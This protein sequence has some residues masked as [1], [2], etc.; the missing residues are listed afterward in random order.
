MNP[1]TILPLEVIRW[2]VT[3]YLD[4]CSF[5]T[6][7]SALYRTPMPI[8]LRVAE[9][10]EIF[11]YSRAFVNYYQESGLLTNLDIL[12]YATYYGSPELFLW[13]LD[14]L[15]SLELTDI[16]KDPFIYCARCHECTRERIV[17]LLRICDER[18]LDQ[19]WLY[20]CAVQH[21]FNDLPQIKRYIKEYRTKYKVTIV[22]MTAEAIKGDN[23]EFLSATKWCGGWPF[24]DEWDL[25]ASHGATEVLKFVRLDQIRRGNNLEQCARL[26]A[27]AAR[28]GHYSIVQSLYYAGCKLPPAVLEA[29]VTQ[30]HLEMVMWA[31]SAGCDWGKAVVCATRHGKLEVLKW[32]AGQ[33]C[34]IPY[35]RPH[36][37]RGIARSGNLAA[38]RW[39][40][41]GG[42][43]PTTT[44]FEYALRSGKVDIVA[45]LYNKGFRSIEMYAITTE[46]GSIA[47]FVWLLSLVS[48]GQRNTAMRFAYTSRNFM[49][50]R[51]VRL[52]RGKCPPTQ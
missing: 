15:E 35:K 26:A 27:I 51:W 17:E 25:M 34:D 40:E 50:R 31:R 14:L 13:S 43:I 28:N 42:S 6:F 19:Y 4:N 45:Y 22:E 46:A 2:G 37:I 16:T 52:Q 30:G 12:K 1:F 33:G 23:A 18:N 11:R 8:A 9:K 39:A 20:R 3:P 5:F 32:L 7:R 41:E 21:K 38:L 49:M 10:V 36:F 29:A 24:K 48:P 47:V 44:T